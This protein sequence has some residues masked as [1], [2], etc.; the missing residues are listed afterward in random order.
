MKMS[1][2]NAVPVIV[3][4][5]VESLQASNTPDHVKY[6]QVMVIENIRDYCDAA[7]LK[8]KKDSAARFTKRR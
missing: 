6:N 2:F 3:Q 5:I 8:Y 7:L 4:Q 1:R